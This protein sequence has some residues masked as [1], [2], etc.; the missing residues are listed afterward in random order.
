MEQFRKSHYSVYLSVFSDLGYARN[1]QNFNENLLTNSIMWG[2]GVSLDYVTYYNKM[3]RLEFT[4]NSLSEKGVF[5]HFSNP[6][7]TNK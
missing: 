6:F 2:R 4:I 5:L 3:I 1:I 7:G